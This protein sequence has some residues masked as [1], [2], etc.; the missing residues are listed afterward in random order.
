[1]IVNMWNSPV[2]TPNL[3]NMSFMAANLSSM[4]V[5]MQK[6]PVI[7]AKDANPNFI[8]NI[9]QKKVK[10]YYDTLKNT[11]DKSKLGRKKVNGNTCCTETLKKQYLL[12][13]K[14]SK[15]FQFGIDIDCK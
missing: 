1:M 15:T 7:T 6:L 9:S 3:R 11:S 5:N 4:T 8:H 2:A 13:G 12:F 14:K 10:Q